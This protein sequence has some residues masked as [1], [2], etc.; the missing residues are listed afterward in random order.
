MGLRDELLAD[1]DDLQREPI[2]AFGRDLWVWEL[3]G[4]Q[5]D[6]YEQSRYKFGK[7]GRAKLDLRNTRAKLVVM[8]LRDSGEKGAK[9][10]FIDGDEAFVGK[11]SGKELERIFAAASK[12]SGLRDGEES[13]AKK[14]L[15]DQDDDSSS[16]SLPILNGV[17]SAG[18]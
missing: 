12:L 5:R 14:N 13:D 2:R 4:E 3:T 10:L 8:A 11:K 1:S 15:A 17:P 6:E 7:D 16:G 18:G 9:R